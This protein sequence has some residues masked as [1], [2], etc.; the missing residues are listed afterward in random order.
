M[1]AL[2]SLAISVVTLS[3]CAS[4]PVQIAADRCW[5]L[6]VGDKVEGTAMLF[7]H[8]P[9]DGCLECGASVSGRNCPGVGFAVPATAAAEQTYNRIVQ[10]APAD[11]NGFVLQIVYLSGEVIPNGAT[12]KPMIRAEQLNLAD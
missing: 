12:G 5:S 7:A 4:Q 6:S 10:T 2:L 9:G 8:K 1:R 3:S 11:K